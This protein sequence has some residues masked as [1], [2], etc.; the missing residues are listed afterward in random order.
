MCAIFVFNLKLGVFRI[1]RLTDNL[2][3][4]TIISIL[5]M[6][7]LVYFA[8]SSNPTWDQWPIALW[9]TIEINVGV[10]C[11]CLPS[12]RLILV[13]LFPGVLDSNASPHTSHP[14]HEQWH[15]SE[16]SEL[17]HRDGELLT[18]ELPR[19]D[20]NMRAS[21]ATCG[22]GMDWRRRLGCAP[23]PIPN[24]AGSP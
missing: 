3:S 24:V 21:S 13:R 15:S 14:E 11:T 20:S 5:R 6:Q 1:Y 17:R 2:G 12:I 9:S 22:G 4:I 8:K 19:A 18:M 16:S 23:P 7:S 10:I